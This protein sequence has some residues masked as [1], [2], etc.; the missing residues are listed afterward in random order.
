M[1]Y[2]DQASREYLDSNG[3]PNPTSVGELTYAFTRIGVDYLR[4]GLDFQHIAEV[5]AALECTKAEIQRRVVADYEDRKREENG[6]VDAI[7]CLHTKHWSI[8]G[9]GPVVA[10]NEAGACTCH[11]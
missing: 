9:A 8:Y 2:I 4:M 1:P 5:I 3:W 7:R 11:S 6:D 10:R